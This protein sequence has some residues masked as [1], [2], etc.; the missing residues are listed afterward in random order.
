MPNALMGPSADLKNRL[1]SMEA[2]LK[3]LATR[4]NPVTPAGVLEMWGGSAAAPPPGYLT[5]DGSAVNTDLYPALFAAIG[6]SYGGSGSTFNLP[7]FTGG[8]FPSHQTPG[9]TGGSATHTHT[10][11]P[12]S[13]TLSSAGWA[14]IQM[15][16]SAPSLVG[17]R[18]PASFTAN[19]AQSSALGT[20]S[21]ESCSEGISLDG[22]T[23]SDTP[24]ATGSASSLPPYVGVVM[25]IKT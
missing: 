24:G 10:S 21:S 14:Q 11:A 1:A 5:C 9:T 17:H 2:Q 6:Y 3:A 23:D 4:P 7:D 18:I 16:A 15:A 19:I 8:K 20:A 22:S 12:H 25:I 13:H